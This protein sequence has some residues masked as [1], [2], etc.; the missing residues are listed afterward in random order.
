LPAGARPQSL[1]QSLQALAQ[2]QA[3]WGAYEARPGSA[4]VAL[5]APTLTSTTAVATIAWKSLFTFT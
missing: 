2:S 1:S 4:V 5:F 3:D